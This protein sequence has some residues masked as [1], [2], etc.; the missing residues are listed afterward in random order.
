MPM[1]SAPLLPDH[2]YLQILQQ[3]FGAWHWDS[4]SIG[5]TAAPYGCST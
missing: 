4:L 3:H 2:H 1:S 5:C